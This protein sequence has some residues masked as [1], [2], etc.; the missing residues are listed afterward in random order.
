MHD[1]IKTQ[2]LCSDLV[3]MLS[4]RSGFLQERN[5]QGRGCFYNS[6]GSLELNEIPTCSQKLKRIKF[7]LIHSL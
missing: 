1:G 7:H 6:S 5:W 3:P 4:Y 2:G